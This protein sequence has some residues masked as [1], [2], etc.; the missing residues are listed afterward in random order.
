MYNS[1]IHAC[2]S[3]IRQG[4]LNYLMLPLMMIV[5]TGL[6]QA[7]DYAV[8]FNGTNQ[9][10]DCGAGNLSITGAN[11]RTVEAWVYTRTFDDRG[12]W[13]EGLPGASEFT[14]R[15]HGSVDNRWVI[16]LWEIAYDVDV[17]GSKNNW[18]HFAMT[19]D[20]S[21]VKLYANGVLI[22]NTARGINTVAGNF[23]IGRWGGGWFDGMIDEVVVYN[24]ARSQS[25][26][27]STMNLER[28]GSETGML[29]Y[30]RGNLSGTTLVDYGP[31]GQNGTTSGNPVNVTGVFQPS[32]AGTSG[33]PYQ[34]AS[35]NNLNW[36]SANSSQWNK[37]Y[38][39]TAN[40]D[41]S[42]TSLWY[43]G[44]GWSPVG[45]SSTKFTGVYD[46]NSH[47]IDAITVNRSGQGYQGFIGATSNAQISNL[48]VTN[49]NISGSTY[50]GSLIGEA[51]GTTVQNCYCTGSVSG[52]GHNVGGL[53]GGN[54]SSSTISKSYS[55]ATTV[56]TGN[57]YSTGGLVGYNQFGTV[58]NSYALGSVTGINAVGGL[59][60]NNTDGTLAHSYSTGA[61]SGSSSGGLVGDYG[62][63]ATSSFW[64]VQ[65]SGQASSQTGVPQSTK[66]MKSRP[67]FTDAGWDFRDA[68]IN[69]IWNIGNDRNNGYPYLDWQYP[70]DP[71]VAVPTL[72]TT[73]ISDIINISASSGGTIS[74][75]GGG[76]VSAR[77]VCWST[78]ATPTIAN[79]L[80][81]DETG[82][83][84]FSSS[85]TGLSPSTTYYVR[86]YAS[87]LAGTAYGN[88]QSFTTWDAM[89][90]FSSSI[91]SH[92]FGTILVGRSSQ[93]SITVTNTGGG[94]LNISAVSD[95]GVDYEITPTSA[96]IAGGGSQVFTLTFA[97]L[98]G[99]AHDGNLSFT[100]N[101]GNHTISITGAGQFSAQMDAGSSVFFDG[102]GDHI[103]TSLNVQPSALTNTT[104]E[105]WIK[106]TRLNYG[107]FQGI[108]SSD[109][110]GW[111]RGIWVWP[112][113]NQ[114]V[115]GYGLDGW[116]T[117][118]QLV[119]GEWYHIAVVYKSDNVLFYLNGAEF[120]LGI[121]P[122]GQETIFDLRIGGDAAGQNFQ[123]EIDE[124]RIWND[125]RTPAEIRGNFGSLGGNE[126]GLVGYWRLDEG[127][128]G[129]TGDASGGGHTGT[130]AYD[131][132]WVETSGAQVVS[133]VL[134][135]S[136]ASHDFGSVLVGEIET[137]TI[138]VSNTGGGFLIIDS[139]TPATAAFTVSPGSVNIAAGNSQ[140]FTVVFEPTSSGNQSG[141]LA[142]DDN[143]GDHT[144]GISGTGLF[145]AQS[146][147]ENTITLNGANQYLTGGLATV[148]TDNITME[149]WV[150]W[151]GQA[152]SAGIM[153]N[154]N[155]GGNGYGLVL[156]D[157]A[158][159]NLTILCGGVAWV[160]SSTALPTGGW[161]H[162][163]AVRDNGSWHL[164][165]DGT[166]QVLS[167]PGTAPYTPTNEMNLGSVS[168]GG[169]PFKGQIDETRIWSV[170]RS[171][172]QIRASYTSLTGNETGL[173]GYWRLDEGSGTV[174]RD[175]SGHGLSMTLVNAPT[176]N[177]STAPVNTPVFSASPASH[178]FG[179]V[180]VGE[181]AQQSI[182]V[183]NTGG[184]VL[185]V[186][187]IST[188]GTDFTISPS[189]ADIL[190]GSDQVF[191]AT[192]T[193][194]SEAAQSGNLTFTDNAGNHTVGL[195]GTGLYQA[196]SDAEKALTFNAASSQYVVIPDEQDPAAYGVEFWA[197]PSSGTNQNI[198]M[199]TQSADPQSFFTQ[200]LYLDSDGKFCHYLFDGSGKSVV[201][202]TTAVADT[203][204]HIV[205]T[206]ENNGMMR[207]FV[208]GQEEGTA[209][210]VGTLQ[211]GGDEYRLGGSTAAETKGY[212]TGSLDELRL[213]D[214][215]RSEVQIQASYASLAGNET[216]L[217]AYL[218]MDEGS[219][220]FT[221]DA[222]GNGHTGT[223]VNAPAW[224][225]STAPVSAPVYQ[226]SSTSL[227]I[228]AVN[229]G[230][231]SDGTVTITNSG[232]GVLN[233]SSALIDDAQFSIAPG[234]AT[235]PAGSSAIF[236]VTFE[237]SNYGDKSGTLT[238]THNP[239]GATHT[240]AVSGSGKQGLFGPSVSELPFGDVQ[241]N[242]EGTQTLTIT[243]SGNLGMS[244]SE[245]VC[246]PTL[247]T[248]S[249][250][251]ASIGIGGSQEFTV[252]F[253]PTVSGSTPGTLTFTH[254][255][256]GSPHEVSITA[257]AVDLYGAGTSENPYQIANVSDMQFLKANT[258][259]WDK[260]FIQTADIN[261]GGV[262]LGQPLGNTTIPFTGSYNGDGHTISN[263]VMQW[264]SGTFWGLFGYINSSSSVIENLGLP[265]VNIQGSSVVGGLAGKISGATVR[266]CYVTGS[267][268]GFSSYV[269]GIAGG[270]DGATIEDCRTSVA[271]TSRSQLSGGLI[272]IA[273]SST[274][275]SCVSGGT[276]MASSAHGG[277]L[278][279][280]ISNT[281]VT[282]CYSRS[283]SRAGSYAGGLIG[284]ISSGSVSASYSAGFVECSGTSGGL[285]GLNSTNAPVTD[286]FWDTQ[287]SA[288]GASAGGT[289]LTTAEL[290][291]KTMFISAGWDFKG[292]T[293]N[294]ENE[295]WNIGN[296]RNGGYP[297]LDIEYPDDPAINTPTLVTAS[298]GSITT[299]S[300]VSGGN[301]ADDVHGQAATVRGV[302]WG[303]S[304]NPTIVND[305]TSN[306]SGSGSFTSELTGLTP[307]TLYH[308]RA[309]ATNLAGTSYSADS[310]FTTL[311]LA[312]TSTQV[313]SGIDTATATGNGT[314]TNLGNPSPSQHGICWSTSENPTT[315]DSKSEAGEVTTTGAFSSA[316]T[317]LS[318]NTTYHARSYVINSIGTSYGADVSFTT[319]Q[320]PVVTTQDVADITVASATA[321]GTVTVVG[322]P[323]PTQHG[324]CWST[325]ETTT[326]ADSKAELGAVTATGTFTFEITGLNALTTY[327]LRAYITNTV[328]T[329]YGSQVSF[330]T[331]IAEPT[332]QALDL[333]VGDPETGQMTISWTN[334][335]GS[336]RVAFIKSGF[337][338]SVEP[339]DNTTYTA[340]TQFESGSQIE[341]TG[342]Y[343][344]Y[345]GEGT[346][347]TVSDL[348]NGES[349]QVMVCEYN[350]APGGENYLIS[351]AADNPTTYVLPY[352][353][354]ETGITL[355]Q[356]ERSTGSWGDID[357]DDDL[358]LVTMGS[359]YGALTE[360][361]RNDGS[362]TF[363]SLGGH[364][365][366][367]ISSAY[368]EWNDFDKDGYIDLLVG[369][370]TNIQVYRNN[371]NYNFT[372]VLNL[373]T[374]S[375]T[376]FHLSWMD[377]D[378]DGYLDAFVTSDY[379]TA[380]TKL[381]KNNQ[382]GT[383]SAQNDIPFDQF[384]Y[385]QA[386]WADYNND[387]YIDVF[388]TGFVASTQTATLY[389]NVDGLS[390]EA[391]SG[392]PWVPVYYPD[393]EWADYNNDGHIDLATTGNSNSY[394]DITK[395]Y[396]NN[397]DNSFTLL[398][399]TLGSYW[400]Y[401]SLAWGDH[402]SDGDLDLV[403][404]SNS[405]VANGMVS[406]LYKNNGDD[407]FTE[408]TNISLQGAY[409]GSLTWGDYDADGDPD[410]L[411]CGEAGYY[412][413]DYHGRVMLYQNFGGSPNTGPLAPSNLQAT[414]SD[415]VTLSWDR[416]TDTET[417][418]N[419]LTYNM[420]IGT[421]AATGNILSPL[422]DFATGTRRVV[423]PGNTGQNNS[424][425]IPGL[426]GGEYY[427]GVQTIDNSFSGSSFTAG[428]SFNVAFQSKDLV[429]SNAT[430]TT[431]DLSWTS[432]EMDNRVVFVK[433]ADTGKPTPVDATTYTA[434]A[435]WGT[436]SQI[437][438]T[439]W[440]C[441][442]NGSD[443]SVTV[444][445][446]PAT[447]TFR[448]MV[449]E[450][451]G[452]ADSEAY[453]L[454]TPAGNPA[455]H[456][457]PYFVEQTTIALPGVD[458]SSID[459]GDY[460]NDGHLD[461]LLAGG[462]SSG[463]IA[464]IYKNNGDNTFTE[465]TGII[466][467]G[468][469]FGDGLWADY[470][471]DGYLDFVLTGMANSGN[472][473]KIYRNNGDGSFSEQTG[474]SLA[475][476][477]YGSA[478]W[479]DFDGD[480]FT[481][482]MIAGRDA[483]YQNITKLFR[484]NG[485]NSFSE[486]TGAGL[487]AS[488]SYTMDW[489]DFDK[490]GDL[491]I[492]LNSCIYRNNGDNTFSNLSGNGLLTSARESRWGD[493]DCDGYL[494]LLI[495]GGYDT[496]VYRNNGN[497]TFSALSETILSGTDASSARWG[498][499]DNDGDLDILLAGDYRTS[500]FCT[501]VYRYDGDNIFREMTGATM[502]GIHDGSAIWCDYDN[503]NDL[504]ILLAGNNGSERITKLYRNESPVANTA[505]EVP[506]NLSVTSSAEVDF[507][508]DKSTDTQT[509]QNALTYNLYIGS[510]AS[511]SE[512]L[513]PHADMSSGQRRI[514]AMGNTQL[515]NAYT[516]SELQEGQY[517]WGVQAIDNG[518]KA[519]SFAMGNSFYYLPPPVTPASNLIFSNMESDQL[520]L[521]WTNGSG[522]KRAV[523][524]KQD[525]VGRPAPV[526][527]VTYV[528]SNIFGSGSQVGN[529]GW[530]CVYD[531]IGSNTT[532]SN[533]G[534]SSI[535]RFAVLEYNEAESNIRYLTAP[536]AANPR[537]RFPAILG[538][539]LA[540]TFDGV[541]DCVAL[542]AE[543][544]NTLS[545]GSAITVEYWFK[546]SQLQ[547]PFRLQDGSGYIV[548]GWEINTP[549]HI[550]STDGGT[551]GVSV[552]D[553]NVV[554]DGNWHHLAMTWESN[555]TD[556]FRSYLD[557]VLVASRNS[558]NVNLPVFDGVQPYLGS[559]NGTGEFLDGCMDEVRVWNVARSQNQIAANMCS[560]LI[561]ATHINLIAYYNCDGVAGTTTLTDAKNESH[562][563]LINSD[564][565]SVWNR[566]GVPM[567]DGGACLATTIPTYLGN[568][569]QRCLVE[570]TS[571]PDQGNFLNLYTAISGGGSFNVADVGTWPENIS[572]RAD[573]IWG[574][575][576]V[577]SITANLVFDYSQLE[578]VVDAGQ[579]H[580][581]KRAGPGSEWIDVTADFIHDTVN[582][583]F[584]K[585]NNGSF[586]EY[587]VGTEGG[588]T[589]LPVELSEF[590]AKQELKTISLNW[591]TDSEIENLG[592]ILERR[593]PDNR[594]PELIEGRHE[595]ASY[596]THEGL[597]GQ[598]ST[599]E[600][601]AYA[602]IDDDLQ[603]DKEYTYFLYD[604]DYQGE[605]T[606]LD[607]ISISLD[608]TEWDR[609][610]EEFSLGM[611]YPNPFNPQ[612]TIP[613]ALPEQAEIHLVIY[614]IRGR[615]VVK[616]A[617]GHMQAG[618]HQLLWTGKNAQGK[619]V[620]SG[621]YLISCSMRAH[622]SG[623]QLRSTQKILKLE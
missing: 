65:T 233:I 395:I 164:Y 218:R 155:S 325:S 215:V 424:F 166:E 263:L 130:L 311:G 482:L 66:N 496:K 73:A 204:Y 150:N 118:P 606:L 38:T 602:F 613:L 221:G 302:C 590:S 583:T 506:D 1:I 100:D 313:V 95:P 350:G 476:V 34:I 254:D 386:D 494:D 30:Y 285:I 565:N 161:H 58:Q 379:S 381:Y 376:S 190:A 407:S 497:S 48:G 607:S 416:S 355:T 578:G 383:L 226:T 270:T 273:E 464:K 43:G 186:S 579:A 53:V 417:A 597:G 132:A 61:V 21:N 88:Q 478:A 135:A 507:S 192:F 304:E 115:I 287:T 388:V 91:S 563:T 47:I 79:A 373:N 336:K 480:G 387:G 334:G 105:A 258:S 67:T 368:L 612:I 443:T 2:Q 70:S 202:T 171:Q 505:P 173:A 219:G 477:Y 274:I 157:A 81:S 615:E 420:Y 397:G 151:D 231:T 536:V 247:Y 200:M 428:T 119:E 412:D 322:N 278:L 581:I 68:G 207:L 252:T 308:V 343:C 19:Y 64:D 398:D 144:V 623:K 502:E 85:L 575:H 147:A 23:I 555:T 601:S 177:S 470:D 582:R 223:L 131:V 435:A 549:V 37:Y 341:S 534:A 293:A 363:T 4:L 449:C 28:S 267:V 314:I 553:Q 209:L 8:N 617:N 329:N 162:V 83:G 44:T 450:Y 284:S 411:V 544:G 195:S 483:S 345:N 101:D 299:T 425:T 153:Y 138:T 245:I 59:V 439:G 134:S 538:S 20:G 17:P 541:N 227:A 378:N 491:D 57:Y 257:N 356:K 143:A 548:A 259:Y 45:N 321:H 561:P 589:S 462:G 576:A 520:T 32:G 530:F 421:N 354:V 210:A 112:N 622:E 587:S 503:D 10:V 246:D 56:N 129:T 400:K 185:H 262:S 230:E 196:Q 291:V 52:A 523:F 456:T 340:D 550:I 5:G 36:L 408:Q 396:K 365:I 212:F 559:I 374:G 610:P 160:T 528:A 193:P 498:D 191:T 203:W 74:S 415:V 122:V 319:L 266:N 484:N 106:P 69:D 182:T 77:G 253:S 472:I 120:S 237:P 409:E 300:A 222:T 535:Y 577:G 54:R 489:G 271:S 181:N 170:A 142:F 133:P 586:S 339:D 75:D 309:Y 598:G 141:N 618:R 526:D 574:I 522:E 552:G 366:P 9:Q 27:Q 277:G 295:Y 448:V 238:L 269:G 542:P 539:G 547:S 370:Y 315:A 216:G 121:A 24:Y 419:G 399:Q 436:G 80:S 136:P 531:G 149:T 406:L 474:I 342:W 537:T 234:T 211:T 620:A 463:R 382:D 519:S 392:M 11:P 168:V 90:I 39:Q 244:I 566:S 465:Q 333:V 560:K 280:N 283:T 16:Q 78:S 404:T 605:L 116:F 297:Y 76:P 50:V 441:V 189:T 516:M 351:T 426:P 418:Q 169:S 94:Y 97:P 490:D 255:G 599:N 22:F 99:G 128:G 557:G 42:L 595:I 369:N 332:L 148:A 380:Y 167:T 3:K 551:G 438:T 570:I 405:G 35:L 201:S 360:V 236:T 335:N 619:P 433:Q 447:E 364:G 594:H 459:W 604:V 197:K 423:Q 621:I 145:Q 55:V 250:E 256:D 452:S 511:S 98:S 473:A 444:T 265:N 289:G 527:D 18:T 154:G 46:G 495:T 529:S 290:K 281:T 346:S 568:F 320:L 458:D 377:Y 394:G 282:N 567:G 264:S 312:Y 292:E 437:G 114:L 413:G 454:S 592:F 317:G 501:K 504:D 41:A 156:Y 596:L 572:R 187:A 521:S 124:V 517:C 358:D 446:L 62:P 194:G 261:A 532:V 49:A 214:H 569:G 208:N 442:Y 609:I 25:E 611:L 580:L 543:V 461:I 31:Y 375:G 573:V 243:N 6:V 111:D 82:T 588:D 248:I 296:N 125:I 163:A 7:Q 63:A 603:L 349:Y 600:S 249:P 183:S 431:V 165:L 432:G 301:V 220:N 318:P 427:W 492:V 357:N 324:I 71:V 429:F 286:S 554:E 471:N 92:N 359:P 353:K 279:G 524:V 393:V 272:G 40:I 385:S 217:I 86:A 276:V 481:D 486:Q 593:I 242:T 175:G 585:L 330:T 403:V 479:G 152:G 184:G 401:P 180:L 72:T 457:Q 84:S 110:G 108:L 371:Q 198:F 93:Q 14:L 12:V 174:A 475:P 240:I 515:L 455:T 512:H 235:L 327:Y 384:R 525:G 367:N 199:R 251:S 467:P 331:N 288:H 176:W 362:N 107:G 307:H 96:S 348:P 294:G 440:Y 344:I 224:V 29:A 372:Q 316:I 225:N 229:V 545:G 305:T 298:I 564:V 487:P 546:G 326:I 109:N 540:L 485:D 205:I 139:V 104:F 89:P 87:N 591:V 500:T 361:F 337:A 113:S 468:V 616:L 466:L 206:A 268:F 414:V 127:S 178:A 453:L 562:G 434:S 260:C 608:L 390:F 310:S 510:T 241:V 188:P 15:T 123:G 410:L 451:S 518:Y 60:G 306:G 584:T 117:T 469:F 102:S 514:V 499:Y 508:W 232:G 509:A 460:D 146:T 328:D 158:G 323:N 179:S 126:D 430:A 303:L 513:A 33:D 159:Q 228:G 533:I 140:N 614:D 172:E 422:S 445:N 556:G 352:F 571:L 488:N 347:V 13:T 402:D 391:Q 51:S 239:N 26:I 103:Q 213:Y 389:K 338:G 493:Y 558:A 137:Q 275:V